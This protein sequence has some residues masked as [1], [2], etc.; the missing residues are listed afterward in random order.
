METGLVKMAASIYLHFIRTN[1]ILL[2]R[3]T[4]NSHCLSKEK[5]VVSKKNLLI[6]KNIEKRQK[7]IFNT[8]DFPPLPSKPNSNTNKKDYSK[9]M[10]ASPGK[11]NTHSTSASTETYLLQSQPNTEEIL[12]TKKKTLISST[13]SPK[14]AKTQSNSRPVSKQLIPTIK[15]STLDELPNSDKGKFT[16]KNKYILTDVQ[17]PRNEIPAEKTKKKKRQLKTFQGTQLQ[18]S[19]ENQFELKLPSQR[20]KGQEKKNF[21]VTF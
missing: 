1:Y 19:V 2:G 4:I 6:Q 7:P 16:T 10:N 21:T 3:D 5:S 8:N 11:Y 14:Q 15:Q 18:E 9:T 13:F 17:Q 12:S 20:T